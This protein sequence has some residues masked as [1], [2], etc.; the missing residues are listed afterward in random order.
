MALGLRRAPSLVLLLDYDGTLVPLAPLPELAAPDAELRALLA[1]LAAR[2]GT[3]VHIA[4]G[5]KWEDLERWFGGLPIDLHAEHGVCHRPPG[6]AWS[7]LAVRPEAWKGAVRG[8]LDEIAQRT[9][10]CLVEEKTTSLA[11]HY[12]TV[13]TELARERLREL[14]ARVAGVVAA[15][16]LEVVR[17]LKVIEVRTRG[18]SKGLAAARALLGGARGRRDRRHRRR[19][20]GRGSLRGAAPVRAHDPRGARREPGFAPRPGSGHRAGLPPRALREANAGPSPSSSSSSVALAFADRVRISRSHIAFASGSTANAKTRTRT[21]WGRRGRKAKSEDET[22]YAQ[23]VPR[24]W[25]ARR[26]AGRTRHLAP[27]LL[28]TA[29]TGRAAKRGDNCP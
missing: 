23:D 14:T 11:W 6:G 3:F 8:V 18:L 2:P 12:R 13:E 5:R 26:R 21:R 9:P 17:G 20:H 25:T 7:A 24:M 15:H 22:R 10:G 27:S 16:D 19:R 1:D 29:D 28:P 4:S